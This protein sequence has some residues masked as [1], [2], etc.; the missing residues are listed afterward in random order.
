MPCAPGVGAI[1][2]SVSATMSPQVEQG[3]QGQQGEQD[4]QE[5]TPN[6]TAL[7]ARSGEVPGIPRWGR[8]LHLRAALQRD[9]QGRLQLQDAAGPRLHRDRG[10]GGAGKAAGAG[11]ECPMGGHRAAVRQRDGNRR[12]AGHHGLRRAGSR[13]HRRR[14]DAVPE[15]GVDGLGAEEVDGAA[16]LPNT[17]S[18]HTQVNE[19]GRSRM[20]KVLGRI[21]Q[22]MLARGPG[23]DRQSRGGSG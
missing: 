22:T 11:Q 3:Q 5:D 17:E 12:A 18:L 15:G 7:A 10:R 2:Q 19:G 9:A 6:P 21:W 20:M 1:A 4:S 16:R 8:Q 14:H 13:L 23:S